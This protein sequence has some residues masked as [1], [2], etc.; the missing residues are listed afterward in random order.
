[1]P[2]DCDISDYPSADLNQS[3]ELDYCETLGDVN[4]DSRVDLDDL[5]TVLLNWGDCPPMGCLGDTDGDGDVDIDDLL[6]VLLSW[7]LKEPPQ[8]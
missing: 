2:N 6:R 4:G 3:G 1:M 5:T 8:P 7:A